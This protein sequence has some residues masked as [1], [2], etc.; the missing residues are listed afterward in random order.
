ML[1]DHL[2]GMKR[3]DPGIDRPRQRRAVAVDDV[4]ALGNQRGQSDL[5]AGMIA[6]RREPQ[7]AQHDQRDEPAEDQHSEHQPLVHDREHLPPLPDKSEPLGPGRDESGRRGVHC[8]CGL[9]LD[10]LA[11]RFWGSG[12]SGSFVASRTGFVTGLAV[13]TAGLSTDFFSAGFAL[14]LAAARPGLSADFLST[15]FAAVTGLSADFRSV[16]RGVATTGFAGTSRVSVFK[17]A[18]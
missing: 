14:D 9:S 1:A 5:A 13:A 12:A 3:D 15:G 6:E 4:A 2:A 16:G 7:D 8:C 11:D 18:S 17:L 10:V